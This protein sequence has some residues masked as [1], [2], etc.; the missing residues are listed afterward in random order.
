MEKEIRERIIF[1]REDLGS[2]SLSEKDEERIEEKI[3]FL[4]KLEDALYY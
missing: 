3:R 4:E 1:L 2:G